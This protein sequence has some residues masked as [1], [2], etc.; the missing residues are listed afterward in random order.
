MLKKALLFSGLSLAFATAFADNGFFVGGDL[1]YVKSKSDVTIRDHYYNGYVDTKVSGKDSTGGIGIKGG[2][3]WGLYRVY[4]AYNYVA[5]AENTVEEAGHRWENKWST[6]DFVAGAD[7]TPSI[8]QNFK[9]MAGAY[10]GLSVLNSEY[11]YKSPN[12]R[13]YYEE[14]VSQT[15]VVYG[16]KVGG[17]YEFMPHNALE[18]G[19]KAE[20][21]DYADEEMWWDTEYRDRKRTNYGA[22]VG[23]TYKF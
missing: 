9:L 23:Y 6:H 11:R 22:F 4:G 10:L 1:G 13:Y 20:R 8:T 12:R 3:D 19:V 5:P 7:F 17:I 18:F 15:G 16:A 2:Y 14:D 21:A